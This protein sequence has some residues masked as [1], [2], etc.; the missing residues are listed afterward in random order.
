MF[1]AV[2]QKEDVTTL[3]LTKD[4]YDRPSP[5]YRRLTPKIFVYFLSKTNQTNKLF[6]TGHIKE[7]MSA[8][9]GYS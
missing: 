9:Q 3:V 1:T 7:V 8:I 4:N 5:S 6:K 2:A